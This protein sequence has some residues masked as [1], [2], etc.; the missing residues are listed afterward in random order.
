MLDIA[1]LRRDPEIVRSSARRRGADPGFV[2]DILRLDAEY[3][4]DLAE[5]ERT[6]AE[7]NALSATIGRAADQAAAAAELRPQLDALA[8]TI[9]SLEEHAR[10]LAPAEPESPLQ[11]L[12]EGSPNVLDDSVPIGS[13][14]QA[15]VVLRLWGE[16]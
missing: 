15:N 6:K 2:D 9:A 5:L 14:E 8:A 16:I 11:A 3:R 13:D 10:I 7:K 12:L 4:R 1:L